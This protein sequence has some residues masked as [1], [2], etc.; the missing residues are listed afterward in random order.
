MQLQAR[1]GTALAVEIGIA[2]RGSADEE[3]L[4][5]DYPHAV[6]HL[7]T[8]FR[9][10]QPQPQLLISWVE[11]LPRGFPKPASTGSEA[12]TLSGRVGGQLFHSRIAMSGG[13]AI[14]WYRAASGNALTTP[15]AIEPNFEDRNAI[16]V[17]THF[18]R[19]DPQ[20]ASPQDL[21][22]RQR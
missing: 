10:G 18:V 16:P 21:F 6:V 9:K 13:D 14:D 15:K 17:S 19:Q 12:Y 3:T 20:W 22:A 11:L 1:K 7:A 8:H 2:E 4:I 5:N